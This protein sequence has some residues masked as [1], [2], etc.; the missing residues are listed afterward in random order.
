MRHMKICRSVKTTNSLFKSEDADRYQRMTKI[1]CHLPLPL[2]RHRSVTSFSLPLRLVSRQ[3]FCSNVRNLVT[4]ARRLIAV[5]WQQRK[6][7]KKR[8][9][10][11]RRPTMQPPPV[12]PASSP[13]NMPRR[14]ARRNDDHPFDKSV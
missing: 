4:L 5:R 6:R 1:C 8:N 2:G 14:L 12:L 9:K 7:N 13:T 11:W 10:L 3:P